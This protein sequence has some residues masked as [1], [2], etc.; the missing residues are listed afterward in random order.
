M[1]FMIN[2]SSFSACTLSEGFSL[3]SF[4]KSFIDGI[5]KLDLSIVEFFFNKD[6]EDFLQKLE[7]ETLLFFQINNYIF[8]IFMDLYKH[9]K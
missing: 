4:T 3:E 2:C 7:Q 8:S 1:Y 6:F 9:K 5:S